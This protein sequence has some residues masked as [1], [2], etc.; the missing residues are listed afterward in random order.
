[1]PVFLR[2]RNKRRE[3]ARV[4]SNAPLLVMVRFFQLV[5]E[6]NQ[7]FAVD[8]EISS[9]LLDDEG[10]NAIIGSRRRCVLGC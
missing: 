9:F 8:I 1:M 4:L 7:L 5:L 3:Q 6:L 10:N 2:K